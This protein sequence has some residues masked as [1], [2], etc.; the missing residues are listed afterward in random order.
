MS[1]KVI[2]LIL[3]AVLP[4][5]AQPR[6]CVG[7]LRF[8]YPEV[9]FWLCDLRNGHT[10]DIE[11]SEA[12]DGFWTWCRT[13]SCDNCANHTVDFGLPVDTLSKQKFFRI[14]ER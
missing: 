12:P 4:L 9:Q 13:I 5:Q 14:V 8:P 3:L 2:L 7:Y 11:E 1:T 10:Y 6:F